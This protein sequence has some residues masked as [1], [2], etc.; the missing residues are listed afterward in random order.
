MKEKYLIEYNNN[1]EPCFT[2]G[3][4]EY[5]LSEYLYDRERRI[6]YLDYQAYH[7]EIEYDIDDYI[8]LREVA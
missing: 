8:V 3:G 7:V 2:M 5:L 6:L 1:G 4:Y